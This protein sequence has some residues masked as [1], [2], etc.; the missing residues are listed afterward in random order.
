MN[1]QQEGEP[2][3]KIIENAIIDSITQLNKPIKPNK[4]RKIIC[5]NVKGTNWTQYQRVLDDMV[6]KGQSLELIMVDQE[7]FISPLNG[8]GGGASSHHHSKMAAKSSSVEEDGTST[9]TTT[10]KIPL[11]IV[12][13]LRR[14]G[15]KKQKNLEQNTKTSF[16]FSKESL[17]AVKK[18]IFDPN[19]IVTFT[20]QSLLVDDNDD[21][22]T[23]KKH[24]KTVKTLINK[25]VKSFQ[26]NPDHYG[27]TKSGGTFQ[28][29]EE[30]K[31]R[32]M[33][34]RQKWKKHS[35]HGN[36]VDNGE[37]VAKKRR[38]KFY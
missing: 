24:M 32:K 1:H 19:E 28:E 20:I 25:M 36:E 34:T 35:K 27:P 22:V 21:D 23:A 38:R 29:Q 17:M 7:R 14:K 12:Y 31:K 4:L 26:S 8:K 13:H 30:A 5:K 2:Q 18:K 33:E 16:I 6:N 3:D 37:S 10:M 15:Q 9:S 11:A